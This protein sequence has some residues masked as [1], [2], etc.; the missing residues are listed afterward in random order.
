MYGVNSSHRSTALVFVQGQNVVVRHYIPPSSSSREAILALSAA[1]KYRWR[2]MEQSSVADPSELFT[3][4]PTSSSASVHT[5]FYVPF[6]GSSDSTLQQRQSGKGSGQASTLQSGRLSEQQSGRHLEQQSGRL[7]EQQSGRLSEQQSGRLTEQQ[8]GRLSEQQAGQQLEDTELF[9]MGYSKHTGREQGWVDL[10]CGPDI[11]I[12]VTYI[13]R[14]HHPDTTL[15]NSLSVDVTSPK[16]LLRV[17]GFLVRDLL[18]L[19][20]RKCR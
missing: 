7:T 5:F 19:K 16:V 3:S 9:P 11:S 20:V 17:Y 6:S 1:N 10:A 8:S 4:P 15:P 2:V 18:A 13:S 12:S 14:V